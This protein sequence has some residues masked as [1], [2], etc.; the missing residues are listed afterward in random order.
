MKT[1][2]LNNEIREINLAY[3][4]LA[5][6]MIRDDREAAMFRLGITAEIADVLEGL[7]PAQVVRMAQTNMLLCRFRFDDKLILDLVT[8]PQRERGMIHAHAAILESSRSFEK[9]A[10]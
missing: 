10:A 7:S 6:Q 2:E 9:V 5:Q 8:N 4:M 1:T 3:L